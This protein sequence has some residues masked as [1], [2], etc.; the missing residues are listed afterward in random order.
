M[1]T[2]DILTL[3]FY[4]EVA[5]IDRNSNTYLIQHKNTGKF[6]VKKMLSIYDKTLYGILQN[7]KIPGIPTIYHVIEDGSQLIVIEEYINGTTLSEYLSEHGTMSLDAAAD[8]IVQLCSILSFLHR[9]IPPIIHRDIKPSNVI[10]SQ[11][12]HVYLIDF[13]ASKVFDAS[14]TRD[15]ILM[16]TVDYAAPEQFGFSQSNAQTDIYALGVLFN[17]LLTGKLPKE[18]TCSGPAGKIIKKCTY[19]DPSRRYASVQKLLHA[20]YKLPAASCKPRF[21][22]LPPGFRT[23]TPWKMIIASLGYV[24]IF[25]LSFTEEVE[26]APSGPFLWAN[27]IITLVWF[28]FVITLCS[29][30]MGLAD[31]LPLTKNPNI[32]IKILGFVLWI[33]ICIFIL[34]AAISPFAPTA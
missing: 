17:V 2:E 25:W 24:F 5:D 10:L 19:I 33:F 22:F 30:Y 20:L 12:N 26:N 16:G 14:K 13:N 31:K 3:S 4:H 9:E 21:P 27:R 29:N 1:K 34:I 28:L 32:F 7:L 11:D 8:I 18:S 15:T 23:V 6:Y